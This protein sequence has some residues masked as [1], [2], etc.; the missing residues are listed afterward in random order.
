MPCLVKTSG[1]KTLRAALVKAL[2]LARASALR[3]STPSAAAAASV[4]FPGPSPGPSPC[5]CPCPWARPWPCPSS[6]S[7]PCCFLPT[8]RSLHAIVWP[9]PR[10]TTAQSSVLEWSTAR[11][12]SFDLLCPRCRLAGLWLP[13]PGPRE[14]AG[15]VRGGGY[16]R[17]RSRQVR[18]GAD[19]LLLFLV[20]LPRTFL[21]LVELR[22]LGQ[23]ADRARVVLVLD[24]RVGR[25]VDLVLLDALAVLGQLQ[26]GQDGG[27]RLL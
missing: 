2:R 12:R 15:P 1:P 27:L 14:P 20:P 21:R 16:H 24:L 17:G 11:S 3:S 18:S 9:C 6:S 19:D 25:D 23:V 5:P 26:R 4:L 7:R 22:V 13:A 8:P 10:E